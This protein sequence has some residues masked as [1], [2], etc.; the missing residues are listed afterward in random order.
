MV[1]SKP[2]FPTANRAVLLLQHTLF[3]HVLYGCFAFA[4]PTRGWPRLPGGA[5][6]A[7]LSWAAT[8]RP[9]LPETHVLTVEFLCS[10]NLESARKGVLSDAQ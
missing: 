4:T 9:A 2:P 6:G 1:E 3:A 10:L 8:L 5:F 7:L